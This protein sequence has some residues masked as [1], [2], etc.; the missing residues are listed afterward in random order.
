MKKLTTIIISA[1]LMIGLLC[2]CNTRT[3]S[4]EQSQKNFEVYKNNICRIAE[5]YGYEVTL[6]ENGPIQNPNK[7]CNII[8]SEDLKIEV[9]F[10]NTTVEVD[11]RTYR[12]KE[13]FSVTYYY[14]ENEDLNLK[15]FA[16]VVNAISGKKITKE[17]CREFIEAKEEEYAASEQGRTKTEEMLIYKWKPL[18]FMEDWIFI[19]IL[20]KDGKGTLE[21]TGLT[22]QLTK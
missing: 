9:V 21:L 1:L 11:G 12:G 3:V 2:S 7:E 5:A 15:L 14:E 22:E 8:L 13:K 16:E 18:N 6:E 4:L 20:N 10:T 17:D 19:H